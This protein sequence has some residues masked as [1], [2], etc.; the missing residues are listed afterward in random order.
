M[1]IECK[2]KIDTL[3]SYASRF[4]PP[5]KKMSSNNKPTYVYIQGKPF[6]LP[7]PRSRSSNLRSIPSDVPPAPIPLSINRYVKSDRMDSVVLVR[8]K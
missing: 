8:V 3:F 7:G 1:R 5:L 4:N 2:K 6:S